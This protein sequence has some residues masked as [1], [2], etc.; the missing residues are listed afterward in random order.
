[1]KQLEFFYNTIDLEGSE[2]TQAI[3]DCKKQEEI[4]LSLFKKHE[5]LSPS[6][7]WKMGFTDT[8]ITSIRRSITNLTKQGR[9]FK[10]DE[11]KDGVYGKRE[12]LWTI[13][14]YL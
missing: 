9:L 6:D 12:H 8:P 3:E 5:K 11:Y 14:F 13:K 10:T 1:M 2:L 4:V 7:V